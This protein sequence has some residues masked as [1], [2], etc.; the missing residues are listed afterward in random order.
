MTTARKVLFLPRWYPSEN[1]I[2]NGVFIQKHAQAAALHNEVA[3]LYA[4]PTKGQGKLLKA[5]SDGL[6][7]VIVYYKD[8][9][10]GFLNGLSYLAAMKK[11]WK[12]IEK[13]GFTPNI[14]HVHVL[15]RPALLGL[16]L[17]WFHRIPFIVSEHWSG[18]LTG[19]FK[20]KGVLTRWFTKLAVKEAS[21]VTVVSEALKIGMMQCGLRADYKVLPNVVNIPSS[22]ESLD[23]P[24]G[25]FTFLSVADLRDDVKNISGIIRA[26]AR[27]I[28]E[29]PEARLVIAGDGPDRAMLEGLVSS[30]GLQTACTF[31]GRLTNDEVIKLIPQTHVTIIN[32]TIETFS[33]IA[34]ESIFSGRPVIAT[35]CGGPEQF[36]NNANGILIEPDN[37]KELAEAM[38]K[39]IENYHHYMAEKVRNS[40][41]NIYSIEKI[42][43]AIDQLY[44][45][46]LNQ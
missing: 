28:K 15:N 8:S 32:S 37:E 17:K 39:V 6:T 11:G 36:I 45:R 29:N 35:R 26:F 16:W 7:E 25:C 2:Q 9:G 22:S 23:V 42:A 46:V 1:D 31:T 33:V 24:A 41:Q 21:G 30:L 10:S 34:L 5:K 19:K 14:C 40:I 43:A 18:Y 13:A 4:E 12:L 20:D 44:D 38:K 3:V 27:V